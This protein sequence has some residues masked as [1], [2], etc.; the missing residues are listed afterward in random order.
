MKKILIIFTV[1]GSVICISCRKER[2]C[3]CKTTETTVTTGYGAGT[4]VQNSS[5]TITK[6]KQ[7]KNEFKL[8]TNCHS[9]KNTKT[10]TGGI[11]TFEYT[12]VITTEENCELK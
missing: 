10:N 9:S 3:E 11:G 12:D 5:T 6:D 7:K 8:A 4:V 1:V 2:T